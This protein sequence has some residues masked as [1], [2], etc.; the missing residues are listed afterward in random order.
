MHKS[1]AKGIKWGNSKPK[2]L[3]YPMD[4]YRGRYAGY[5]RQ[6]QHQHHQSQEMPR[7]EEPTPVLPLEPEPPRGLLGSFGFG[8]GF[9]DY[10]PILLI[11]IGAVGVYLWLGKQDGGPLGGLGGLGGMLGGFFK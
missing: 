6:E 9:D 11:L 3:I 1:A 4:E 10:L 8:D 5:N 7:H 2:G